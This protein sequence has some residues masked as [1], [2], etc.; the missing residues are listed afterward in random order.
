M[1][2]LTSLT[3]E[4]LEELARSVIWPQ[5]WALLAVGGTGRMQLCPGS[6]LDLLLVHPR[7]ADVN[8][9]SSVSEAIW[10]PLW[11]LGLKVSSSVHSVESALVLA[12]TEVISAVTWLDGRWLAGEEETARRFLLAAQTQWQERAKNYLPEL[13]RVT[14]R[15]HVKHGE[16]AFLLEP[17]LRDGRGGLRDVHVLRFLER[18]GHPSIASAME[19]PVHELLPAHDLLLRVRAELHRRT[20]RTSDRLLLQ[21]QD[22]VAEGLGISSAD[23][24]MS[25]VSSCA[26]T[27]A[28]CTDE[29]MRR[30]SDA[31]S[32]RFPSRFGKPLRV[33]PN[34]LLQSGELSFA[35]D[36]DVQND[37]TL[38]L[39]TAAASALYRA[40][41][42]R[43]TLRRLAVDAPPMPDPWP[44]QA[45]NALV[46]LLGAGVDMLRVME[47]LDQ[48]DL[49][50][51]IL[52]E[53]SSVRA[54]P[55]RNAYH[56][57]T[58]DRHLCETAANAADLVRQVGR[59]DL[60]LVGAWL[61]DLGKGY[62]GD[63]TE[64]GIDLMEVIG[65]RMGFP[66]QDVAVLVDLVRHHLLIPDAA[67][68]RD[69]SDP[70]TI[71][72]IAAAVGD[73]DRLQLLRTLTEADSIATGPTAW[74]D[75]KARLCDDLVTRT[76]SVLGGHRPLESFVPSGP[77]ADRL[78]AEA[79]AS[80]RI[81]LE[82]DDSDRGTVLLAAP[83]RRGL[84]CAIAGSLSLHGVD[85]IS[86]DAWTTND[87]FALDE[88]CISR[89][90][91]GETDWRK[92]TQTM[93]DAVDGTLA[94]DVELQ[95]RALTYSNSRSLTHAAHLPASP[96]VLVSDELQERATV[97][98][99]R[100]PDGLAV[101]YRVTRALTNLDLDIRT[102]KVTTLGHEVVD[103]FSVVRVQPDGTRTKIGD[104]ALADAIREKILAE[105]ER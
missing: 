31:L 24:L 79:R 67:T 66:P 34:L 62:L 39:R 55:Q 84:F 78:L 87:G 94:L 59:P 43:G 36:T 21:E 56:R 104:H 27:I 72:F 17:E 42:S 81:V 19:R 100:A 15:R 88:L 77:L 105:L 102:A 97:V 5:G 61:H 93:N 64:V 8:K 68:R 53:W 50:A 101:L 44:D 51:R 90:V 65:P 46:A 11:D 20:G 60:L 49:I 71:G 92:V 38:L 82:L 7:K 86:A 12:D 2:D 58:V 95:R 37:A 96:A 33:G 28:W 30:L 74:S 10:Y 14:E 52:P 41:I 13:V 29:T 63:H 91:G 73:I 23:D 85:V 4:M 35:D 99:V 47:A 83:D 98:E 48:F 6:D 26:R 18:S 70:G 1:A 3:Y 9:I 54:K 40:A 22:A 103:A 32:K 69:L 57:F 16:V 76:E 80:G 89:R 45:R 25:T 75:W